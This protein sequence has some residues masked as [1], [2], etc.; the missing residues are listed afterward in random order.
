MALG[1]QSYSQFTSLMQLTRV[2]ARASLSTIPKISSSRPASAT[3]N[4]NGNVFYSTTFHNSRT[5]LLVLTRRQ[6]SRVPCRLATTVLATSEEE[7]SKKDGDAIISETQPTPATTPQTQKRGGVLALVFAVSAVMITGICNRLLYKMA[8]KPLGSYVFFLAQL[9]TFGYCFVYIGALAI[10]YNAG[11]VPKEML[12][13]PRK[14]AG[15]FIAIGF[16][17]ALSSL[18]SF[19]SAAN[20]PGVVLPL[21]GQTVLFWQVLL[22]ITILGKRLGWSQIIGVTLVVSGVALAAWPSTATAAAPSIL[23]NINPMYAIIFVV[24]MLFPALDTILKESVFRRWREQWSDGKKDL[25]LFIL[26]SFGSLAQAAFVFALLPAIT[27]ARGMAVSD[28]PSYLSA[29]W[30]CVRGITPPCGSDC[31]GAPLIP[32][33][34]VVFNLAFNVAALQVI[35]Q[36]GNVAISLIMSA[37]VPATLFAFTLPL[38]FLDPAPPLGPNF[39]LGATVLMAGLGAYNAPMWAPTFRKYV[40]ALREKSRTEW[41]NN[42]GGGGD[43]GRDA[44][45]VVSS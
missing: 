21:L 35:R 20:L 12:Q 33:L 23:A 29:G 41:G 40:D 4:I 37:I 39:L 42:N 10:R 6:T 15:T 3:T 25:D 26:N 22:A 44:A 7:E 34:Y 9:Q 30:Q 14:M 32:I 16:I 43:G 24:S 2:P 31:T 1:S 19:I 36:A 17:E 28:L 13:V 45:A 38:P 11:L 27:A 8:L 18:L 5:P